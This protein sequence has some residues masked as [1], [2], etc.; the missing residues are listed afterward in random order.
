MTA[1]IRVAVCQTAT[2]S[3][4]EANL[5]GLS[6]A[7]AEGAEGGADLVVL[8]ECA[9]S[10]YLPTRELD[11]DRLAAAELELVATAG[12]AGVWL[13]LGTTR[14]DDGSWLWFLCNP[15]EQA[16]ATEVRLP[17]RALRVMDTTTGEIG[18]EISPTMSGGEPTQ[19]EPQT[20]LV[21]YLDLPPR[22][23]ALWWVLPPDPGDRIPEQGSGAPARPLA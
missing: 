6:A 17:G 14:L 7:V 4:V 1:T 23:H 18:P 21:V 10:G 16:I 12:E 8:P 20:S 5:S 15:W 3:D 22:G 13:V 11:L 9:L 19:A 2:H